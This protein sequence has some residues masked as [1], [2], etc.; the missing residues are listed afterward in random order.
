MASIVK[1]PKGQR[2]IQLVGSDGKRRTIRLGQGSQRMAESGKYR[3]EQ[4]SAAKISGHAPDDDT[5]RWVAGLPGELAAKLARAGLIPSRE[6]PVTTTLQQFLEDYIA[7]RKD[8]EPSTKLV[9]GHTKRNLLKFFGDKRDI[10][11]ITPGD[12]DQFKQWLIGQE[13]ASTTIHKRLQFARTFFRAMLRRKLIPENPFA[14]VQSPAIGVADRQRFISQAEINALLEC[15]PDHHWR[16]IV[17]LSRYGGLRTPSETLSLRWQDLNWE[18][19]RIVVQ[20]PK[21]KCHGKP[22]RT[23]PLFCELRE[24]LETSFEIAPEGAVYVVDERFRKALKPDG[25]WANCNLRTTFEKIIERAGLT[26]W[27]RL[28]HNLRASR[29][30][31]LVERFP[32]QVVAA[33]LGNTPT[34]ALKHYLMTTDDHFAKAVDGD[35]KKATQHMH[36]S[37]RKEPQEKSEEPQEPRELPV[38]APSCETV[39]NGEVEDRGLEPHGFSTGKNGVASQSEALGAQNDPLKAWL[40]ACPIRLDDAQRDAIRTLL[41]GG[42]G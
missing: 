42:A 39:Q 18:T 15:C 10:S 2:W 4:L 13:Y 28:F 35:Q 7:E 32:V 40:H 27:P 33:W 31:E 17:A 26:Q 3:V 41:N 24:H 1:R 8:V 11:T 25:S 38:L 19:N 21:T 16:M 30:T 37:G 29:E 6:P 22:S 34:I 20:S 36:A 23:I 5:A 14:E 12:A 9:W